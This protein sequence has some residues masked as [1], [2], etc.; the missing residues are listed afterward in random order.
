MMGR[1][2]LAEHAHIAE[3]RHGMSLECGKRAPVTEGP[4]DIIELSRFVMGR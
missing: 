4:F 2:Q 3:I 1:I